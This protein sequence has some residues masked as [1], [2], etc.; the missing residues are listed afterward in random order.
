MGVA[1]V[2]LCWHMAGSLSERLLRGELQTT[3]EARRQ[4]AVAVSDSIRQSLD[5]DVAL[6]HGIP[7]TM[8]S[9]T[10]VRAA[11]VDAELP[12]FALRASDSIE[13]RRA[14]LERDDRLTSLSHQFKEIATLSGL[15]LIWLID[16]RGT[17]IAS[18]NVGEPLSFVG[19]QFGD[20]TYMQ[21]VARGHASIGF[22]RGLVTGVPG[23]FVTSPVISAGKVVGA[24]VGK[25]NLSRTRHWVAQ[26]GA[27]VADQ[28]GV[29][30]LAHDP[31]FQWHALP[32][33]AALTMSAPERERIYPARDIVALRVMPQGARLRA[34]AP[35]LSN[36]LAEGLVSIEGGPPSLLRISSS[37]RHDLKTG[38]VVPFDLSDDAEQNYRRNRLLIFFA[39]LSVL[40]VCI[41]LTISYSRE[42]RLHRATRDLAAQLQ[43][44]NDRLS[45]E[46]RF[47]A[48]TGALSRRYFLDRLRNELR[49]AQST[50]QALS[51]MIADLD[52]FKQVNDRYGHATG[53]R[54]LEYFHAVCARVLRVE[55]AVGRLGGE[56]FGILLPGAPAGQAEQLAERIRLDFRRSRPA[57][58]P[59][60]IGLSVSIGIAAAQRDDSP[61]RLLSR[62]DQALYLAKA[63]GRNRCM[64]FDTH[65]EAATTDEAVIS[66]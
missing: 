45:D 42:R 7:G 34:Q 62:A 56:E 46:A 38:L 63:R 16:P 20:R 65:A 23:I 55:D 4:V 1:L 35:W 66:E 59:E 61:E 39:S 49:H 52:H 18:S 30:I 10:G 21:A 58:I 60:D 13:T 51:M 43:Q 9:M 27:F 40:A 29:I 33:A 17:C 26:P 32:G 3:A 8:A 44:A 57:S 5:G 47:D 53:D 25:I 48:L 6:L 28:N 12:R 15:D 2:I 22:A 31:K 64:V 36:I 50:Q 54:A 37:A 11:L 41:V 14:V 24:V 19:A